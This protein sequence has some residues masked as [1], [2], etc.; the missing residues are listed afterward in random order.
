VEYIGR[1][2]HATV[3]PGS[4]CGR[5]DVCATFGSPQ[6]AGRLDFASTPVVRG[7]AAVHARGRN[8]INRF[9]GGVNDRQLF[10]EHTEHDLG[11][12]LEIRPLDRIRPTGGPGVPGGQDRSRTTAPGIPAWVV[13]AVLHAVRDL[14]DGLV[15]VGGRTSTGLGTL[16][17]TQVELGGPWRSLAGDLCADS[18]TL[19]LDTLDRLP[20]EVP[21]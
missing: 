18:G 13:R 6:A 12:R 17:S 15:G 20:V 11:L 1:S 21:R 4:D 7:T 10:T 9:T 16:A 14:A 5:C 3:C 19:A 8:A 2:L